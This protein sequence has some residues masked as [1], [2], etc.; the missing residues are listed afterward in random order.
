MQRAEITPLHSTLVNKS[1][2]PSKNNNKAK[3]QALSRCCPAHPSHLCCFLRR[4]YRPNMCSFVE[5]WGWGVGKS[6]TW[7]LPPTGPRPPSLSMG[8]RSRLL[9]SPAGGQPAEGP[10]G[11]TVFPLQAIALMAVFKPLPPKMTALQSLGASRPRGL[12]VNS[13]VSQ[14]G[15][16]RTEGAGHCPLPEPWGG[17]GVRLG[18]A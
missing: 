5:G 6:P 11:D 8:S 15:P 16:G 1:E 10:Q 9:Y 14:R 17:K 4:L 3:P 13:P 18:P 2:T 7:P 12:A